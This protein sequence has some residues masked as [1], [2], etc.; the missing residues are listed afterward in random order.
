MNIGDKYIDGREL[1]K[2]RDELQDEFDALCDAVREALEEL[3]LAKLDLATT[4]GDEHKQ[5][6][7]EEA[8]EALESAVTEL[9][10]WLGFERPESQADCLDYITDGRDIEL[11]ESGNSPDQNELVALRDVENEINRDSQLIHEDAFEDYARELA[12][13]LHGK[14]IREASW[15]FD[16]IDWERAADELRAD[17]TT[18]EIDGNTYYVRD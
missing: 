14:E 6:S 17:Y 10:E 5:A 9:G 1:D 3:N 16:C 15:P 4:P 18:V 12:E 11:L 8:Q 13:D 7:V 2:R